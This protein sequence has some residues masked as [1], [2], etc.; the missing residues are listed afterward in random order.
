MEQLE[1]TIDS[2][3]VAVMLGKQ[4]KELLR[5]IRGYIPVLTGANLRSSDY[6]IPSEYIDAKKEMRPCY[7]ITKIGCDLAGNKLRGVKGIEFTA[8]YVKRFDEMERSIAS[9]NNQPSTTKAMLQAAL[10]HEERL[11]ALE[12]KITVLE[13]ETIINS[14][15]RR[16]I[17]GRVSSAVISALGGKK[18]LAYQDSGVRTSAFRNCYREIQQLFDVASYMDIPKIH[19]D[20]AMELIPK[21]SPSMELL[22][23]IKQANEA[24]ELEA[25]L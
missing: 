23:R 8:V 6:F 12:D 21:W 17:Q 3:E 24:F 2:R 5:D 18:S 16:K 11:D 10:E 20:E 14:S 4:H 9:P 25:S 13:E 15:Q 22:S 1:K 7:L 19:F